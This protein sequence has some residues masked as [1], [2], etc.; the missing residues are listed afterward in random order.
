MDRKD[1]PL[2]GVNPGHLQEEVP[3]AHP[4][5]TGSMDI[6]HKP[7]AAPPLGDPEGAASADPSPERGL[8]VRS[9]VCLAITVGVY[10][11]IASM[12]ILAALGASR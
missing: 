11:L 7:L 5:E 6:K 8:G 12:V 1:K 10:F 3:E 9:L 4:L 2:V